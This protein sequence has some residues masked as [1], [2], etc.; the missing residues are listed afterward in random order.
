MRINRN[1]IHWAMSL[2]LASVP[3]SPALAG[4]SAEQLAAELNGQWNAAFN[5]GDAAAVAALY[6]EDAT[7]SPGNGET[8]EGRDSI[9][10]LFQS[11]IDNGVHDHSI[12]IIEA[13]QSGDVLYEVARWQAHSTDADGEP[14]SFGGVLLNTF[15]RGADGVWRSHVHVWNAGS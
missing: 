6:A 1:I 9:R 3:L 14:T 15:R 4:D 12:E 11:F 10:E 5:R 2:M 7:L 13:H 8:L